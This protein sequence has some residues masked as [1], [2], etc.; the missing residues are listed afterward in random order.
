M[1]RIRTNYG[2]LLQRYTPQHP[3]SGPIILLLSEDHY[4]ETPTMGWREFALGGFEV[5]PLPGDHDSYIGEHV[6]TTAAQLRACL[7]AAQE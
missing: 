1:Q 6:S 4:Q 2:Q 7:E 5:Y 3:Y